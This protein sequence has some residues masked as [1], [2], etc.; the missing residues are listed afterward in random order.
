MASEAEKMETNTS[1]AI[2]TPSPLITI[3]VKTPKDKKAIKVEPNASIKEFK[4]K[5]SAA[6][7][8]TPVEQLCLIFAGKMLKDHENLEVHSIKENVTVHLVIKTVT[9]NSNTGAFPSSAERHANMTK[10]A[11]LNINQTPFGL[12]GVGGLPGIASMGMGSAN[13]MELQHQMQETMRNNPAMLQP[14]IDSPLTQN[15][16]ANPEIMKSL[17]LSNP[18]LTKLMDRNPEMYD[19]MGNQEVLRQTMDI[20]RNPELL[21]ELMGITPVSS[22]APTNPNTQ[23]K[24]ES[25]T[26]T[27]SALYSSAGMHSLMQQMADNPNIMQNMMNAPYTQAMLKSM[28]DN[29]EMAA[30]LVGNSPL[31]VGNSQLQDQMKNMMPAFMQQMQNPAVH[32]LMANPD[33]LRSL[34]Q[35]QGG[36]HALHDVSPELYQSLGMPS[37]KID[38]TLEADKSSKDLGVKAAEKISASAPSD[39]QEQATDSSS[40]PVTTKDKD[41]END[42]F[43]RLMNSMVNRMVEDGLNSPPEER[44][45]EQLDTLDSLGFADKSNNIK[46]LT[47]NHGDVNTTIDKLINKNTASKEQ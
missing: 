16:M 2:E 7:N 10:Q 32:N 13:F 14:L 23:P 36:L 37:V 33:A 22:S 6:F 46:I 19:L 8:N 5:I 1:E 20:S 9:P 25:N 41:E 15:L 27:G 17:I 40:I 12:G 29:P 18:Q 4:V 26:L 21:H 45:K 11:S 42:P 43:R 31:F 28:V 35:I 24:N 38:P 34:V 30:S 47:S 3:N 44:F 39:T